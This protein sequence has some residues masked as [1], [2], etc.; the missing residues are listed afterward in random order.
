MAS[1]IENKFKDTLVDSNNTNLLP[2]GLV[3]SDDN[4]VLPNKIFYR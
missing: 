1:Y 3:I 2:D 4:L